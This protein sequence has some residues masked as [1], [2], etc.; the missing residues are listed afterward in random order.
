MR[1]LWR[2][3]ENRPKCGNVCQV[4]GDAFHYSVALPRKFTVTLHGGPVIH[5][6]QVRGEGK[7]VRVESH[8]PGAG[9][10]IALQCSRPLSQIQQNFP[11]AGN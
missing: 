10:A 4:S 7:I 3:H 6:I 9:F 11:D 1:G 8:G 5:P 2:R